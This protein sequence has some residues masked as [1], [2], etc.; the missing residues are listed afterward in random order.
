MRPRES[1]MAIRRSL[2]ITAVLV[3]AAAS[4]TL[5]AAALNNRPRKALEWRTPAEKLNEHLQAAA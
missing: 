3:L 1:S 2:K 5:L 4:A